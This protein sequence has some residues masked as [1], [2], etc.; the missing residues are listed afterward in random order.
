MKKL[1]T[2]RE[3]II[4][5]EKAIK[6]NSK[7]F[8]GDLIGAMRH[9]SDGGVEKFTDKP[10]G[11]GVG[12]KATI[13]ANIQWSPDK[14]VMDPK[15][16]DNYD[17]NV[18]DMYKLLTGIISRLKKDTSIDKARTGPKKTDSGLSQLYIDFGASSGTMYSSNK[19]F[20]S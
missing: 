4:L 16:K 13:D 9:I 11:H 8:E 7:K 6:P 19:C 18:H 14:K 20:I 12:P 15:D 3:H 17:K 10:G 5:T 2:L 1:R